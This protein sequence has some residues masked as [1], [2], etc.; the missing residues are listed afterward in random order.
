MARSGAR[1]VIFLVE[2]PFG[3]RRSEQLG[4]ETLLRAGLDVQLWDF[5]AILRPLMPRSASGESRGDSRASTRVFMHM[6][7]AVRAIRSARDGDTMFA[8]LLSY[9]GGTLPLYRALRGTR[10]ALFASIG[11][12][13]GETPQRARRPS[14][15]SQRTLRSIVHGALAVR[16]P[17]SLLGV[18]V[19][20]LIVAGGTESLTAP[21]SRGA[22]PRTRVLWAHVPDYDQ[23]LEARAQAAVDVHSPCI[24]FLDQY[25]A[26]HPD[27]LLHQQPF[28]DPTTYFANLRRAFDDAEQALGLP[29]VVA[30]HPVA[31]YALEDEAFGGRRIESGATLALLR[32]ARLVLA[33]D[34][35]AVGWAALLRRPVT[36]LTDEGIQRSDVR[37]E[38]MMALA[39]RLG[40]RIYNLDCGT[41]PAWHDELQVDARRYAEYCEAF[42]KRP[43][44]PERPSWDLFAD[45]VAG[46]ASTEP[47]RAD[48]GA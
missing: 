14:D 44:S 9:R 45:Y 8:T 1:R 34:S 36:F 29:V 24:V 6:R 2:S 11:F 7:D 37:R 43:G 12:P 39:S 46:A 47:L 25:L 18:G 4:I 17:K 26:G 28:C 32:R 41:T 13:F 42:I 5:A 33:H 3:T 27:Q 16:V 23:V 35:T 30:A 21:F 19:P 38:S 22:G 20:E 10:F 31:A 48:L 40:R 15:D